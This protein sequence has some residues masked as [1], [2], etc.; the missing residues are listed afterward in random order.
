M[1]KQE[2]SQRNKSRAINKWDTNR[3]RNINLS[4]FAD[5]V[6]TH[7][8]DPKDTTRKLLCLIKH[9]RKLAVYKANIEILVTF[10]PIS[11]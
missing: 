8:K 4:L 6:T 10:L 5:Y 1:P 11:K 2:I 9:H 3:K 7:L